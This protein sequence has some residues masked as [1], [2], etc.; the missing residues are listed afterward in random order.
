MEIDNHVAFSK[1]KHKLLW[2]YIVQNSIKADHREDED[3]AAVDMYSSNPHWVWIGNYVKAYNVHCLSEPIYNSNELRNAQWMMVR[4]TWRY[5]YPEPS[6]NGSYVDIV[7]DKASYCGEC[8]AG[9]K[10]KA[11]FCLKKKPNW[12]RRHFYA[13][14]WI[15]DE[16]FISDKVKEIFINARITGISFWEVRNKNGDEILPETWQ[17]YICNKTCGGLIVDT[18]YIRHVSDCPVCGKTKYSAYRENA[19]MMKF[20]KEA[21][22]NAADIVKTHE[23]FGGSP[24]MAIHHILINQKVYRTIVDNKLDRGLMFYPIELI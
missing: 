11:A 10:Q 19:T 16:L 21:L 4:T 6:S 24:L 2:E 17:L 20:K 5:G 15:E 9:L 8:G 1:S 14:F 7:Y 3:I 13:P 22:T 23:L 12:G 18:D